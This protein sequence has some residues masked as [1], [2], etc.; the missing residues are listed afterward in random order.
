M[1]GQIAP[2]DIE[3]T[4]NPAH[5]RCLCGDIEFSAQ[6]PSKWVAHCHCTMCQR[7]GGSAFVTWVGLDEDRCEIDD[8]HSQLTWYLSSDLGQRGFCSHCG[9]TLFFRSQRWA[10]ELHVTLANFTGPVDRAP[11]AHVF[12]DTHVDWVKLDENDGL[13]RKTEQEVS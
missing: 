10:G 11:Q 5:G 7:S 13:P 6:L 3:L 1:A 8:P 9:S 2:T 12:W 4:M